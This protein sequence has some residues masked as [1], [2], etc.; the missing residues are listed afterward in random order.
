MEHRQGDGDFVGMLAAAQ[1]AGVALGTL[2]RRVRSGELPVYRDPRDG[3]AKLVRVT[4]LDAAFGPPYQLG[5][6]RDSGSNVGVA[7]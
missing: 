4:D 3:R 2:R 1:R 6:E 5:S 7:A